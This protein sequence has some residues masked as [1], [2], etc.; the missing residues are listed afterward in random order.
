MKTFFSGLQS[1]SVE[2]ATSGC[3]C[4]AGQPL[5]DRLHQQSGPLG[6]TGH[7]NKR[8]ID[9]LPL[10]CVV[11]LVVVYRNQERMGES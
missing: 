5:W 6:A 1:R 3:Q 2:T 11:H 8:T 9:K 10:V 4:G 7:G